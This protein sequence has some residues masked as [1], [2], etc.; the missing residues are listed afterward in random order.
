MP[1]EAP[2]HSHQLQTSSVTIRLNDRTQPIHRGERYEDPLD[3][4]LQL[5]NMGRVTGGGTQL[6]ATGEIAFCDIEVELHGSLHDALPVMKS[7]IERLGAPR[8]SALLLH[9]QQTVP[10]GQLEGM[11]I[12]LDGHG[13]PEHV[14]RDCDVNIVVSELCQNLGDGG[15]LHSYWEGATET[16]LYFYGPSFATMCERTRDFVC[17]YPLCQQARVV[18]IA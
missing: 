14:Y 10:C 17:S 6:A 18:Q 8:G 3:E 13:L 12:Y 9:E 4:V 7:E 1:A 15:E 5:R 2:S 16:A 11:A